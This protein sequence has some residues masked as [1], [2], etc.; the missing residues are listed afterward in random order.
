MKGLKLNKKVYYFTRGPL[1]FVVCSLHP[2]VIVICQVLDGW[3]PFLKLSL[4]SEDL[5]SQLLSLVLR[6]AKS[7][8]IC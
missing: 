1:Q 3:V 4:L 6:F 7:L 8:F 5:E 2:D